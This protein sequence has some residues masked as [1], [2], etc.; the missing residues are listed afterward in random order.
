MPQ[1][2]FVASSCHRVTLRPSHRVNPPPAAVTITVKRPLLSKCT[3]GVGV[4]GVRK[5]RSVPAP[6]PSVSRLLPACSPVCG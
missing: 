3:S 4:L 2:S 1:Q 5:M 6:W